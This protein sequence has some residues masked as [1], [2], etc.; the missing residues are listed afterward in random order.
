[1]DS[2]PKGYFT[3]IVCDQY[4]MTVKNNQDKYD[5]IITKLIE[6]QLSVDIIEEKIRNYISENNH[7]FKDVNWYFQLDLNIKELYDYGK[8][9]NLWIKNEHNTILDFSQPFNS[10]DIE[11]QKS[12]IN[13]FKNCKIISKFQD[14]LRH[15]FDG[16]KACELYITWQEIPPTIHFLIRIELNNI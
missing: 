8:Q 7:R 9:N 15:L 10:F 3:K 1:M 4:K 14:N 12:I 16:A 6:T 2:Y 11:K 5:E 13:F